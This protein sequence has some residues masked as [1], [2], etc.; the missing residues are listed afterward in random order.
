[1]EQSESND[2]RVEVEEEWSRTQS[3]FLNDDL[4]D[5]IIAFVGGYG[6]GKSY[7]GAR[8]ALKLACMNSRSRGMIA[9]PTHGQLMDTAYVSFVE[10]L[11][12][13]EMPFHEIRGNRPS[14]VLP[15]GNKK[16]PGPGWI[17]LRSLDKPTSIKGPTLAWAWVDE[18]GSIEKGEDA[19][20][21][22][23]SRIRCELAEL[24][25]TI[26]TTTGEAP[27][28]RER[29]V[30]DPADNMLF[31][32]A[33]TSEN[34]HLPP[35]YIETLRHNLPANLLDVYLDGGFMPP[36]FG[37]CYSHFA[38]EDHIRSDILWNPALP[39][40]HTFD[41]NVNPHCSLIGQAIEVDGK[42]S[43]VVHDEIVI[44][45]G[46]T[47]DAVEK[48]REKLG[49]HASGI[50]VYGDPSGTHRSTTSKLSDYAIIRTEYEKTYGRMGATFYY[51]AAD[52]GIRTRVNCTNAMLR[53][54]LGE[55]RL[56]IHP[57]CKNL[58]YDLE[59]V[60]WKKDGTIDKTRINK[61]T[62]WTI[63]HTSDALAYWIERAFPI[64]KPVI[65]H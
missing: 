21:V 49:N 32:K 15:W 62:G 14:I 12:Q 20:D 48:F 59:H 41:F 4:K 37:S 63:S 6:S 19:F 13:V 3:L 31:Y 54:S 9:G 53:N 36:E 42:L 30:E 39:A 7:V 23:L 28:L 16:R 57:R 38:R 27:W 46:A 55:L 22:T 47:S 61:K 52:P 40:V 45:N 34:V 26:V 2:V 65:I 17:H 29:F 51:R 58:I 33:A 25:Q 1:M 56:F 24:R 10:L 50:E 18:A 44:P 35:Q 64:L 43:A 8:K 5:G 11:D 60:T